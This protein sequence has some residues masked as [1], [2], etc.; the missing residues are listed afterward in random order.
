ML[1]LKTENRV[2]NASAPSAILETKNGG[3][4]EVLGGY[5]S[6]QAVHGS[7][8]SGSINCDENGGSACP[9]FISRDS[10]VTIFS[11]ADWVWWSPALY[12]SRSGITSNIDATPLPSGR[13]GP[14]YWFMND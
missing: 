14:F 4:S 9:M 12:V 8:I 6:T 5:N 13:P 7:A 11:V 3:R 2:G 1:G 10:N